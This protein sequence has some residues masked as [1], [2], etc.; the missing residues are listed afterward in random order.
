MMTQLRNFV[1][2][3]IPAFMANPYGTHQAWLD[4][5]MKAYAITRP[6]AGPLT[7]DNWTQE[8]NEQ[9]LAYLQMLKEPAIKGPLLGKV[10]A[11]A[12]LD[13]QVIPGDPEDQRSKDQAVWVDY[14]VNKSR[15]GWPRLIQ[16]SA[17]HTLIE[18][19]SVG[20]VVFDQPF[21]FGKYAG[22]PKLWGVKFKE[23]RQIYYTLDPYK[24]VVAI[25]NQKAAQGGLEFDPNYFLRFVNLPLFESPFGISDL[26]AAYRASYLIEATIKLRSLLLQNFSGP[27]LKYK[28]GTTNVRAAAAK[29][30]SEARG[31]GFI[32]LDKN[33]E[34]EVINLATSSPDQF[35]STID[36]LRKEASTGITGAYLQVMESSTSQGNSETHKGTSE[37]FQWQ[38]AATIAA[39]LTEQLIPLLIDGNYT[40]DIET[41]TIKLGA[42]DVAAQL[43]DAE[44]FKL[45]KDLKVPASRKQFYDVIGL[46]APQNDDDALN[47]E[48]EQPGMPGMPGMPMEPPPEPP[49][50][51]PAPDAE[52]LPTDD[53][54]M[55][56]E[57][58]LSEIFGGDAEPEAVQMS[59]QGFTGTITDKLGRERQYADGK[60]VAK[61]KQAGP[62][63]PTGQPAKRLA[64]LSHLS[65]EQ[66]QQAKSIASEVVKLGREQAT[67]MAKAARYLYEKMAVVGNQIALAGVGP[68]DMLDSPDDPDQLAF[69]RT[70]LKSTQGDQ[71]AE[72]TGIPSATWLATSLL[73]KIASLAF[74]KAKRKL[75]GSKQ[76]A[77]DGGDDIQLAMN[78][79]K[80]LRSFY[81]Y[82]ALAS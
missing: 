13:A 49:P 33:D 52:P 3:V 14:C 77:D 21:R 27:F 23:T 5:Q 53:T 7:T 35:Q 10:Y 66:Q 16:D 8:T 61:D 60:P 4:E 39:T 11:V 59:D 51:Q 80:N 82:E 29:V 38:L 36:D 58:F 31:A 54:I 56:P 73:P 19:F 44:R 18:G 55:E 22:R 40:E 17:L 64:N 6:Y 70:F 2:R 47:W 15:G 76:M 9:K 32:V 79:I 81:Q 26:R 37:L 43:K 67:K 69:A 12:S 42:I 74:M 1:G 78:L 72:A 57:E 46:E 75:T 41:P 25:R 30:L 34:L 63:K 71:F 20:E 65:P 24:N 45:A 68:L 62:G 50:E 48:E 28:R